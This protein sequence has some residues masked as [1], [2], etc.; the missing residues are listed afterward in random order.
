MLRLRLAV[1]LALI[2]GSRA[3][4]APIPVTGWVGD[5]HGK[6][7]AGARV[8][9]SPLPSAFERQRLALA[10]PAP[11]SPSLPEPAQ[12]AASDPGGSFALGAEAGMWTVRLEAAGAVPVELD[13]PLVEARELPPFLTSAAE[14]VGVAV[15]VVDHQGKPVAAARISV[16]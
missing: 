13:L 7:L 11:A 8:T 12:K 15:R 10:G 4:A 9:L 16:E 5:A 1:G 2:V 3:L 6:P 14:D